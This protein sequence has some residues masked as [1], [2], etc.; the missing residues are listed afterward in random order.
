[1]SKDYIAYAHELDDNARRLAKAAPE[2]MSTFRKSR[3]AVFT[4]GALDPK[5]KEL[6][7]VAIGIVMRCEGCVTHHT[8]LA[9][10]RGA[11]REELVEIVGV[12]MQLG[13]GPAMAYGGEALAAFDQFAGGD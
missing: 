1:M 7:A 2:V 10:R 5:I 12:C 13:G 11:T 3:E 9:Q 8:K 6:V 4:D